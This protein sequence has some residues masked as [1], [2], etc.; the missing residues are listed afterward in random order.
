MS[1]REAVSTEIQSWGPGAEAAGKHGIAVKRLFTKAGVQP[2]D[3]VEWE[4]RTASIQNDKGKVNF[5]AAQYRSAQGLD[6][7]RHQ[8]R[9]IK[10][11]PRQTEYAG[12]RVE[13]AAT[14]QPRGGHHRPVGR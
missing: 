5:R 7:D 4:M 14:D 9:G 6:S 8:H 2:F 12:A 11:L 10:V 3:D 1:E 13:R